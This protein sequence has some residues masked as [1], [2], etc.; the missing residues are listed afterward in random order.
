MGTITVIG[1][2]SPDQSKGWVAIYNPAL[3]L[4]LF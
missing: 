2:G 3:I 1:K 4:F